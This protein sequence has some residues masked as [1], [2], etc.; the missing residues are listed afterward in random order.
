MFSPVAGSN[1]SIEVSNIGTEVGPACRCGCVIHLGAVKPK[2]IVASSSESCPER[3]LWLVQGDDGHR[4]R[5]SMNYSRFPCDQQWIKVRDGEKLSN[6][7]ILEYASGHIESGKSA[8]SSGSRLLIEFHS[9]KMEHYDENCIAGFLAQ[10][11]QI[12]TENHQPNVSV[13]IA[14]KVIMPFV[15]SFSYANLTLAH[16]CAIVFISA[17][18]FITFILLIQ[19]LFRYRKYE[20]AIS[21]TEADSPAHTLFGSGNSLNNDQPRSRAVSTTTLISEIASYV[22]LRPKNGSIK[23]HRF[24]ESVEYTLENNDHPSD[25]SAVEFAKEASVEKMDGIP[26]QALNNLD[27]PNG[28][29]RSECSSPTEMVDQLS[30]DQSTNVSSAYSS[31]NRDKTPLVSRRV[32]KKSPEKRSEVKSE[33]DC[34]P[35][36]KVPLASGSSTITLTNISPSDVECS[37]PAPS[38]ANIYKTRNLKES[39]EKRNLR[40]LLAGSDF[41]LGHPEDMEMDYYDYN[42]TNAGAAPGS[43]LGMDPAFLVW[44]PPLNDEDITEEVDMDRSNTEDGTNSEP[45]ST[46]ITPNEEIIKI[47]QQRRNDYLIVNS[48]SKSDIYSEAEQQDNRLAKRNHLQEL[49]INNARRKLSSPE[50]DSTE[51]KE[52]ETSFTKSPADNKQIG[53]FYELADIQFADDENEDEEDNEETIARQSA[54]E[55]PRKSKKDTKPTKV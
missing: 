17:I 31:L 18:I 37:S 32:G 15:Q 52:K 23:H 35:N 10:A 13:S 30:D 50:E 51:E 49:A 21:Q 22:K 25:G 12:R 28:R 47:L 42:V 1:L 6:E 33:G 44:I 34:S 54:K 27:A 43:Y 4:I 11:E 53:D 3:S 2:R 29:R 38:I 14:S 45:R 40:K 24:R 5:F 16:I 8:T 41:S 20:L 36:E 26:M 48:I 19:Y 55:T 39:K 7:L 46:N 9:R